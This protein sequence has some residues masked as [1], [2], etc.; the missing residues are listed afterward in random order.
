MNISNLCCVACRGAVIPAS[1]N[2]D[3]LK[4]DLFSIASVSSGDILI[5]ISCK[6]INHVEVDESGS[7]LSNRVRLRGLSESEYI[8][9]ATDAEKWDR[10]VHTR[11]MITEYQ[12]YRLGPSG[13]SLLRI[14]GL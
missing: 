10:I 12:D 9:L 2:I 11:Q 1:D 14:L 5:C 3:V 13:K 4:K 8:M 7:N 6:K